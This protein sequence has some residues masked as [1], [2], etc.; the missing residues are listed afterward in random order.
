MI[1]QLLSSLGLTVREAS[2]YLCLLTLGASKSIEIAR[3]TGFT[4]PTIYDV[5]EKLIH[6]GLVSKYKKKSTM[7]FSAQDPQKLVAYLDRELD[8][9]QNKLTNQKKQVQALLPALQSMQLSNKSKPR[10]QFFEGEKGMR[11][12][13]EDTLTTKTKMYAYTNVQEMMRSLPHFFPAYFKRR[14][15]KRIQVNAVFVDNEAGQL[16]AKTNI[17]D[18]RTTKF[19]CDN[20]TWSP[21]VK[22]YDDKVLITSWQEKMA[23]IIQSKEYADLQRVI[24]SILW[25]NLE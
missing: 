6:R 7:V 15:A 5:I 17:E 1:N 8:E 19:F 18:L 23:I 9:V 24:F 11:E 13:Y 2:V 12:A 20:V 22:I 4:R 21:E 10:V 14:T 16:L 3:Y 25:R